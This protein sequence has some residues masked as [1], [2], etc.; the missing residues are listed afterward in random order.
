[1]ISQLGIVLNGV[2]VESTTVGG[3]SHKLLGAGD[4]IVR[5]DGTEASAENVRRLLVGRDIPESSVIITVARGGPQ[6]SGICSE[7]KCI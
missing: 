4:V 2:I 3:P 7:R 6:V 1:M 5:I